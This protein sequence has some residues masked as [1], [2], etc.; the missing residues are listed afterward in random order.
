MVPSHDH[1]LSIVQCS[2]MKCTGIPELQSVKDIE[3]L[4]N[5]FR[6][7]STA[8]AAGESFREK[9]FECIKL[10]WTVQTNWWIHTI[11]SGSKT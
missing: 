4:R 7:N 6:L 1:P 3:Y 8:E 11:V 9:I 10:A 5:V 2:Q